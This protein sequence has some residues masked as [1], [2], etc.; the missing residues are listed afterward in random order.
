M[1]RST[2]LAMLIILLCIFVLPS[3]AF[4]MQ[5]FVKT[6]TGKN[7]AL[8]VEANDTIENVKAK[9]QDKEGLPPDQQILIFAGKELEEGRTLAD[10]NIQKDSTLHLVLAEKPE[11]PKNNKTRQILENYLTR[12]NDF[13]LSHQPDKQR[14]INR[15]SSDM[16][17]AP[18]A[19]KKSNKNGMD[20]IYFAMSSN[21]SVVSDAIYTSAENVENVFDVWIEGFY[22]S[23]ENHN[24]AGTYDGDQGL[25]FLGGDY[26]IHDGL[27]VGMIAQFDWTKAENKT[28]SSEVSG[29]GWMT[30][31]YIAYRLTDKVYLDGRLAW[32]LSE[33]EIKPEGTY[34][35]DFDT[36]RWL[37]HLNMTGMYDYGQWRILPHVS[38]S[39][40]AEDQ[41][42]YT[43]SNG[44]YMPSQTVE[45]GQMAFGPSVAYAYLLESG[46]VIEPELSF[47]G[48][49]NF[50]GYDDLKEGDS[51][52]NLDDFRGR[53]EGGL[54]VNPSGGPFSLGLS[55]A[56]DG[57]GI[58]DYK[59]VEGN[60]WLNIP[61]N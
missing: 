2:S 55:V 16:P 5:I 30:G 29:F 35:D 60:I 48:L 36:E 40:I 8:E 59:A 44:L 51:E 24:G 18:S 23:S 38:I 10:Y 46:T 20:R 11:E 7:I 47:D 58:S 12:R 57:I 45:T 43:D 53:I 39:Y 54:K 1:S 6:L 19:I 56:Y 4:A 3:S 32:G 14:L 33:N 28:L 31:P 52:Y 21:P 34:E 26:K 42:G 49:W 41:K 50:T 13:L 15:I 9:I 17:G 27:I 37:A 22:S 25:L 61:F